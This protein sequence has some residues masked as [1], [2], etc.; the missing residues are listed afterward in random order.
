[1]WVYFLY[2]SL[3]CERRFL[4]HCNDYANAICRSTEICIL[5]CELFK[6]PWQYHI[7]VFLLLLWIYAL[8]RKEWQLIEWK[9][10]WKWKKGRIWYS[11]AK[12][13]HTIQSELEA[14]IGV[15][16]ECVID[17]SMLEIRSKTFIFIPFIP[18]L[19]IPPE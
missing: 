8:N 19:S 9:R 6:L 18:F 7:S 17:A 14:H 13:P 15:S 16:F 2:L 10:E 11:N 4:L 1:M 3:C 5:R 12:K